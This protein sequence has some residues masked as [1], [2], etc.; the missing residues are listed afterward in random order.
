MSITLR[1]F[2]DSDLDALFDWESDPRAIE[3]AAFRRGDRKVFDAHY[4][5]VRSDPANRLL[6]IDDDGEFVGTIGSFTR[7]GEREVT[8][9]IAPERWGKGIASRALRAFLAIEQTR[10]LY[11]RVAAHN[12]A[13]AKV[14]AKAGFVEVGSETSCAPE[15]VAEV[16][17]RIYRLDQ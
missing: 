13:S 7:E 3:M 12:V 5:R 2:A 6:A 15:D 1:K 16:I 8:Y 10:P 11:G 17:E 9:W 14:L 4:A